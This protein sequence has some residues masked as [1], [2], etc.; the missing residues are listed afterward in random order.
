MQDIA[1]E[2]EIADVKKK[3]EKEEKRKSS[4]SMWLLKLA[5]G[6]LALLL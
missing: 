3:K 4:Y 1:M 2:T 5:C 6:A